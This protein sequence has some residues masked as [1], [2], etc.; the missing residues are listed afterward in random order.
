MTLLLQWFLIL[1]GCGRIY[2]SIQTFAFDTDRMTMLVASLTDKPSAEMTVN[3]APG[4]PQMS[5]NPTTS[6]IC[7]HFLIEINFFRDPYSGII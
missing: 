1:R 4:R 7:L 6:G 2:T 5:H 3:I